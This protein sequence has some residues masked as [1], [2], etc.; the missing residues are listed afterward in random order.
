[1]RSVSPW[2]VRRVCRWTGLVLALVLVVSLLP[3]WWAVLRAD[4]SMADALCGRTSGCD[5]AYFC[6]S[7]TGSL[8]PHLALCVEGRFTPQEVDAAGWHAT[9]MG[10]VP[11]NVEPW[12]PDEVT[13]RWLTPTWRWAR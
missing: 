13:V 6:P 9:L 8:R 10:A 5:Q 11:E 1:M 7:S 3:T 12:L 4:S 2:V